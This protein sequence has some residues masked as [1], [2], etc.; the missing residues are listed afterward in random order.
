MLI[1]DVDAGVAGGEAVIAPAVV[2]LAS[3]HV[4][5]R[6]ELLA[7]Q[8]FG[9]PGFAA[10]TNSVDW[11]YQLIAGTA[12]G[13]RRVSGNFR[14]TRITPPVVASRAGGAP[15]RAPGTDRVDRPML[16]L[17]DPTAEPH[18]LGTSERRAGSAHNPALETLKSTVE[19][20]LAAFL[21]SKPR[22]GWR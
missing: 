12:P 4:P 3:T 10:W 20:E 18:D 21:V 15:R 17:E 7:K 19:L 11:R 16:F 22:A 13:V 5:P 14:P 6:R 1:V 9:N 2:F 8:P